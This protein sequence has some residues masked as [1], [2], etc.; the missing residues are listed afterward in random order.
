MS[1]PAGA[2]FTVMIPVDGFG[3]TLESETE[4]LS[5]S[6][7]KVEVKTTVIESIL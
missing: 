4:I 6:I 2:S 7:D 5:C 3:Y 1:E